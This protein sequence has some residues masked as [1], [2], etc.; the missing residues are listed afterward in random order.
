[1][2]YGPLRVDSEDV[3][4]L[5]VRERLVVPERLVDEFTAW[6]G[7]DSP[8]R[9]GWPARFTKTSLGAKTL[10]DGVLNDDGAVLLEER[11]DIKICTYVCLQFVALLPER[12]HTHPHASVHRC[13]AAA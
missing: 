7:A 12:A 13:P 11:D 6:I 1:M 4:Y 9:P 5:A 8:S 10:K 3:A 2:L